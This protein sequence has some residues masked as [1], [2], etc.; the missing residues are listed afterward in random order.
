MCELPALLTNI[1]FYKLGALFTFCFRDLV[2]RLGSIG[3]EALFHNI[4]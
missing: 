1:P 4:E 3:A 2:T